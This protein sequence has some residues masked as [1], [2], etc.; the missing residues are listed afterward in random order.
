[1]MTKHDEHPKDETAAEAPE[2]DETELDEAQLE[3]I[4][5]GAE[6]LSGS[7]TAQHD[8]TAWVDTGGG[9][10]NGFIMKDSIIVRTGNP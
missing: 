5:G 3:D 6:F 9:N 1:M 8:A 2:R 10:H 7:L 4:K